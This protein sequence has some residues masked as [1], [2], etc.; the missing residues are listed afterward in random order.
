MKNRKRLRFRFFIYHVQSRVMSSPMYITK[1]IVC[2]SKAS[3]T[4]D[5]SY[6]L[7]TQELGMVWAMARS[8]RVEKSKQRCAMQDF[9]IIRISLVQGKATWRI[10][11][12]EALANPFL[13]AESRV[14]RGGVSFIVKALRR[15]VHG[16][17]T[18]HRTFVDACT[19][20]TT[21]S[22]VNDVKVVSA[23][24]QVF[25]LRML[26]EL[27]YVPITDTIKSLVVSEKIEDAVSTYDVSLDTLVSK[28]IEHAAE[29]SQL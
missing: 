10:G 14:A 23:Y 5:K 29:V 28:N 16:E 9:S 20:L 12:V 1:A 11:S 13:A 17:E 3:M 26:N 2:G 27:G 21:L 25:V 22:E 6:L 15:Y 8:V 19:V 18:V 4:S 7:F 24:Q